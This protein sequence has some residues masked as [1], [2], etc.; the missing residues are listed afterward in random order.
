M[1]SVC[2][3]CLYKVVVSSR[4]LLHASLD[5][6]SQISVEAKKAHLQKSIEKKIL[7]SSVWP[8]IMGKHDLI[9]SALDQS[10]MI[11]LVDDC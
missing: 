3:I 11:Y 1:P 8:L 7:P 2:L 4:G 9:I 6:H 5:L 10:S